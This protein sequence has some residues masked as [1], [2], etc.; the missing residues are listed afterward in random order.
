MKKNRLAD[1]I[2]NGISARVRDARPAADAPRGELCIVAATTEAG[3]ELFVYGD[4]GD[5]WWS[6]EPTSAKVIAETLSTLSSDKL[7]VRINSYGGA[8]NE[9]VAIYNALRFH[10]NR[11]GAEIT[12]RVDGVAASIASLITQAADIVVMPANTTL[13]IHAPWTVAVGSI[14]DL[15]E[16][17]AV[18]RHYEDATATS[19]ANRAGMSTADFK[20]AYYDGGDHYLTAEQAVEAGFADRV[21]EDAGEDEDEGDTTNARAKA[22]AELA[23]MSARIAAGVS[24][25]NPAT[26]AAF[27]AAIPRMARA[28]VPPPASADTPQPAAAGGQPTG[29]PSMTPEEIKAAADKAAREALQKLRD[30]NTEITALAQPH[31][32]NADVR[33]LH[34]QVIA[35]ADPDVSAADVGKRILALLAKD[36]GPLNAGAAVVAGA[37]ERDKRRGAMAQAIKARA[38]FDKADGANVYRGFTLAEMARECVVRAG[39]PTAG[40]SR[41]DIVG[42]AFTHSSS[43]FPAVLGDTAR[44]SVL[45]GYQMVEEQIDQFTRAV[46]V[47]DFKPTSLVGLGIFSDLLKVPEGGEYK[48]GTFSDL[49]Q[50]IQLATYGRLFSITRQA[51]INDALGMFDDVGV[52]MGQSAKRTIA[53]A[54]YALL[55]SNPTLADGTA[56]FHADHGNLLTGSAISTTSVDA[57]R[58][59]MALQTGPEGEA[60]R[61]PLKV[62]AVPTALGGLARTVR[63]S[64]TEVSG[65]KNLTTPNIVRNTFDVVDD[66]RLQQNSATAWYGIADPAYV[67]GIVVGY[68][69]GDQ[70]PYL[71][72]HEGFTVDGVAWKV[73][74]DAAAAIAD[75]RGL[76]KNPGA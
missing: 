14:N 47:A 27:A 38:G 24:R 69:D 57:M 42:L 56:L 76:I 20:A 62:L 13:M 58:V 7:T 36:T 30:R 74:M 21:E 75:Y 55:T 33:A 15:E 9:G 18:L 37:D 67:D 12:A 44:A 65:S 19:Y 71:E 50:S 16:V 11:T 23:S 52:K 72:Q 31:F 17:I 53:N 60:I 48:Y 46:S 59:A 10:K 6:D 3:D 51:I 29:A 70:N 26:A 39:A 8:V 68:L 22:R 49:S 45:R 64:Q 1:S 63:E 25:F 54:V 32:H 28:P 2:R 41:M 34:D 40:L 61:V 73:R 35:D 4:I 5:F 66:I 43:D